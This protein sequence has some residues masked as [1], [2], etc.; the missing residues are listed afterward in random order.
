MSDLQNQ[1]LATVLS[2]IMTVVESHATVASFW[3]G[4]HAKARLLADDLQGEIHQ[5]QEEIETL[6]ASGANAEFDALK[7]NEIMLEKQ[8]RGLK[9]ENRDLFQ[10]KAEKEKL[11]LDTQKRLTEMDT[12]IAAAKNAAAVM[13]EKV[14]APGQEKSEDAGWLSSQNSLLKENIRRIGTYLERVDRY[15]SENPD[16]ALRALGSAQKLVAKSSA[17]GGK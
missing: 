4:E 11:F 12:E 13:S 15:F 17:I 1:D 5:L 16:S 7:R 10:E 9:E 3:M 14:S 6:G 2:G 8:V